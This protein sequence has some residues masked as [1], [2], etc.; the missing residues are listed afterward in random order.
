[1]AAERYTE[2][3]LEAFDAARWS[4]EEPGTFEVALRVLEQAMTPSRAAYLTKSEAAEYARVSVRTI[5]RAIQHGELHIAGTRGLIRIRPE[6]IDAWL[7][8]RADGNA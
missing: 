8:Q 5:E 3:P 6:W 1:M 4:I 7:E 2:V